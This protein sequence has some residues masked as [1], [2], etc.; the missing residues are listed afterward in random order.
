MVL[1][2]VFLK[3]LFIILTILIG[4]LIM[5]LV[6]P[7][8]YSFH[9]SIKETI[10]YDAAI[11]LLWGFFKIRFFKID[12]KNRIII[13]IAKFCI[14]VSQAPKRVKKDK[15][16]E[17]NNKLKVKE[18]KNKRAIRDFF[19]K[20]FLY[21]T[22]ELLKKVVQIIKPKVFNAN[23]IYGFE[24]PA[25]TGMV[26]GAVSIIRPFIPSSEIY[27]E[28]IFD[29]EIMDIEMQ[30]SG[31]FILFSILI[32]TLIFVFKKENRKVI[33]NKHKNIETF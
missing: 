21:N 19:E 22:I 12:E 30:V 33:F 23:G 3:A 29:D 17:K 15:K 31:V 4:L 13:S 1:L 2:I 10:T 32:K 11:R 14:T 6:I 9:V 27:L 5:L 20:Q 7:F 28:P 16:K 26:C 24:D 18:N 8:Q 25:L